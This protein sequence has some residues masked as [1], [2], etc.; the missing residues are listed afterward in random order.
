M[1]WSVKK[2]KRVLNNFMIV[3]S[4]RETPKMPGQKF[5]YY[6]CDTCLTIPKTQNFINLGSQLGSLRFLTVHHLHRPP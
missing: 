2:R 4:L 5:E 3:D 1:M 6:R